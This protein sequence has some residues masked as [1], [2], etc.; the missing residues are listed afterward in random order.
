MTQIVGVLLVAT[1]TALAVGLWQAG[2]KD[3]P[4]DQWLLTGVPAWLQG[5][6]TVAAAY[7]AWVAF[8]TWR[9]QEVARNRAELAEKVLHA[10]SE[11][12]LC[13]TRARTTKWLTPQR[14]LMPI[15][16]ELTNPQSQARV[17]EI[18][19]LSDR[20]RSLV[21]T[22]RL[23]LGSDVAVCIVAFLGQGEDSVGAHRKIS[24]F[25]KDETAL[26]KE[27]AKENLAVLGCRFDADDKFGEATTA[28][29]TKLTQALG[30][31]LSFG[32]K[33]DDH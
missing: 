5:L 16:A 7:V 9:R 25:A 3:I 10:A 14:S 12:Y 6:G 33:A 8:G 17:E 18:R 24:H 13:I 32:L 27:E 20:L 31:H 15:A 26:G 29:Y 30:S 19:A 1:L 22:A 4:A 28:A 2:G 23:I 11:L 21:L